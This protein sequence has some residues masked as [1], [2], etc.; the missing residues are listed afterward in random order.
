MSQ[1]QDAEVGWTTFFWSGSVMCRVLPS[2]G[3]RDDV[4]D[5]GKKL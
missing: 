4:T 3:V 1:S 2:G 5:G